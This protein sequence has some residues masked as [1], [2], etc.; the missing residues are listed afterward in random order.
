MNDKNNNSSNLLSNE[1]LS[2]VYNAVVNS[3]DDEMSRLLPNEPTT[4]VTE[5]FAGLYHSVNLH[6]FFVPLCFKKLSEDIFSNELLRGFVLNL[7][8]RVCVNIAG[9][10]LSLD[11]RFYETLAIALTRNKVK[12]DGVNFSAIN[13]EVLSSLYIGKEAL[14]PFMKDNSWIVIIYVLLV[15]FKKTNVYKALLAESISNKR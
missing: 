10:D 11:E 3:F 4:R 14:L 5:Y 8:D 7:N 15:N 12:V 1:E 6:S 13:R 2:V 9:H